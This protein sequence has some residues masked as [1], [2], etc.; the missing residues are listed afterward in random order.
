[1]K[2]GVVIEGLFSFLLSHLLKLGGSFEIS[3]G[4]LASPV[5]A[6]LWHQRGGESQVA[7]VLSGFSSL[8]PVD[9]KVFF[10]PHL[11]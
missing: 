7:S 5:P 6:P 9:R 1:M 2:I 11:N 4:P 10:S 8:A 3:R